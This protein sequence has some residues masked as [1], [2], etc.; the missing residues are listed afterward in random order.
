MN[1]VLITELKSSMICSIIQFYTLS[2]HRSITS[3]F[4]AVKHMFIFVCDFVAIT[5]NSICRRIC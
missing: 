3:I 2:V 4:I 1:Y 5:A